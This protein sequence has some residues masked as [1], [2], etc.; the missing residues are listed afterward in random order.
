MEKTWCKHKCIF[1]SERIQAEKATFCQIPTIRH[2]GKDKAIETYKKISGC[3][4]WKYW[5]QR[6]EYVEHRR[7]FRTEI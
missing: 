5:R 1:L 7:C 2:S 4:D 3:R 6:D